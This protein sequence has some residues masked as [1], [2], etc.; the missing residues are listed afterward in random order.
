MKYLPKKRKQITM[1]INLKTLNATSIFLF[2]AC[3]PN[4]RIQNFSIFISIL[5]GM[6]AQLFQ[7]KILFAHNYVYDNFQL[8]CTHTHTQLRATMTSLFIR[9]LCASH[10]TMHIA[11]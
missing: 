8:V 1:L 7:F 10:G 9:T 5:F 3:V 2:A 4:F 6:Y 11:E